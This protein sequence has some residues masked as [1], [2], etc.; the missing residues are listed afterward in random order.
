MTTQTKVTCDSC[1]KPIKDDEVKVVVTVSHMF[2]SPPQPKEDGEP[3]PILPPP[4]QFDYH[5]DHVPEGVSGE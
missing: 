1:G 3:L 5:K 2:S 4:T